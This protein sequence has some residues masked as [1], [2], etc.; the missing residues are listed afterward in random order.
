MISLFV[1]ATSAHGQRHGRYLSPAHAVQPGLP[2]DSS[3]TPTPVELVAEPSSDEQGDASVFYVPLV[4]RY[5]IQV[6][7]TEGG[8]HWTTVRNRTSGYVVGLAADGWTFDSSVRS[9]NNSWRGGYVYGNT[10]GCAWLLAQNVDPKEGTPTDRCPETDVFYADAGG[11][12]RS[13]NCTNCAGPRAVRLTAPANQW[14]NVQPWNNPT[15]GPYI[16]LRSRPAG[17]CVEWRYVTR[18]GRWVMAKDRFV[19]NEQ[20]SWVFIERSS[21]P[22]DLESNP[23]YQGQVACSSP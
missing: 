19:P 22:G 1:L 5:V 12:S 6:P 16:N 18:D 11:F 3:E 10:Q 23:A 2:N 13:F 9:D 20:G 14:T 8:P 15:T 21:F 17:Y 4:R 7:P